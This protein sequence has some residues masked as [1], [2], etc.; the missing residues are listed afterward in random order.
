[1]GTDS[2]RTRRH[3]GLKFLVGLLVTVLVLALV[4]VGIGWWTVQRSFPETSGRIEV[5]GL[6]QAVTVYRDDAGIPQL[7]AETSDD[8]FFAQGYVHAQDRFWEM[9]FRRHVTAGRLSELFGESQVGTDT[10]IRTLGWRAVAELE[11]EKMSDESREYYEAYAAGVNAYL[12]SRSGADLSLEYAVLGLQNAGY[13]PEPWT[14]VDSIAWLKA[15]AWDL[16]SNLEDEIDRALLA[17]E[18]PAE[19][20]ARLHPGYD[21]DAQPTIVGGSLIPP[22]GAA[23]QT[24]ESAETDAD[25]RGSRDTTTDDGDDA[26][27]SSAPAAPAAAS[28]ALESLRASLDALP[29]LLGPAGGEIG[30]NSWVVG[31][32]LTDTGLPLLAN[33]P[34]LGPAMPS[35]WYQMGLRCQ[36]VSAE[37]PWEVAGYSF[38]GMPGIVI[39]HNATVSWGFTNLGPDVAD[40]YIE[41]VAGTE[42]ELDGVTRPLD[43]REETIAVAGGEPVQIEI[44]ATERGPLVTGLTDTFGEVASGYPA[45]AGLPEGEYELSLQWTAL[46]PGRTPEAIFAMNR[47]ANWDQFRAAA[48]LFEVPSQNLVYA[49]TAG[50]IGYQAPGTVPVRKSGDGTVPL[51]GWTSANGWSGTVPFDAMPRLFNPPAGYIVTANNAVEQDRRPFLTADWDLGYRAQQIDLRLREH[52]D[53]GE[54]ITSEMMSAIQSDTFDANAARFSTVFAELDVDGDAAKGLALLDGWDHRADAD[55]A[56]AAYF[57]MFWRALL[58]GMFADLPDGTAP[59][60]GDRWFRVV[61]ELL[62]QPDSPY[63]TNEKLGVAGRDAMLASALDAAW[64]EG[65]DLMGGDSDSWRWGRLHTLTITNGSFGESGIAP[66]EW[67]FNRGPW[68]LGGGSAIVNAIGWDASQ[69]YTVDWVPSM[70]MVVDLADFDDST[71]IN[72]TGASGH[73]FHPNYTDQTDRWAAG[74]TRPWPYTLDAVQ[75]AAV[76]TLQLQPGS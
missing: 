51:P 26:L 60:G 27:A 55:S 4:A 5:P 73:A 19:E 76:N 64:T 36:T 61:D 71:W 9:D 37:C 63:W 43:I 45:A 2:P 48:E 46:S 38:S 35:I 22:G 12:D 68:E 33:D 52:I 42:Y 39:G 17:T 47:S 53:A 44:R 57:A 70:R 41:K 40:L 1:M 31:G 49:D 32:E 11:W 74:E 7:V 67:L 62:D 24:G 15:M 72:L 30:S 29:E 25:A 56:E 65:V 75:E 28:S 66:I 16:R 23:A 20:V 6:G 10:F 34:H 18:L 54:P 58:D 21:F 59:V 14:P 3:S 50:N 13:E 69:G 8:L